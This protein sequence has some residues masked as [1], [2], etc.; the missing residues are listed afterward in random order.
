MADADADAD[1]VADGSPADQAWHL[2]RDQPDVG[3][4]IAGNDQGHGRDVPL[5]R[6]R[7]LR[8]RPPPPR[9]AV[10]PRPHVR[11]RP[12]PVHGRVAHRTAPVAG[13]SSHSR[14]PVA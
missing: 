8:R 4:V 12:R 1:V 3:W 10:R 7:T 2:L 6:D 11:G 9:A 13:P 14:S 5:V